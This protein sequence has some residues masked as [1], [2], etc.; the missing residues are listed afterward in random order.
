ML[1]P[2]QP[3]TSAATSSIIN[4]HRHR[5]PP[6]LPD[7]VYTPRPAD[8]RLKQASLPRPFNPERPLSEL[9]RIRVQN[10]IA[11]S[12]VNNARTMQRFARAPANDHESEGVFLFGDAPPYNALFGTQTAYEAQ[13][14]PVPF[15]AGASG[16]EQIF[17]P[18][19]HP[20]WGSCLEN[21]SFYISTASGETA[22]FT[23]FNFCES[24][25]SFVFDAIID[26][27]F[28]KDYVRIDEQGLP[29][30]VS[31]IFTPD[32]QPS[33]TST[34]YSLLY[35]FRHRRYDIVVSAPSN[36][37]FQADAFGWSI[38]EPYAAEG[39]CPRIAPAL[40]TNLSTYNTGTGEWD[41]VSD[42][43]AGGAYSFIGLQ[44]GSPNS[45]F[46]GD[47]GGAAS[48]DFTLLVPNSD[49]EV[50]SPRNPNVL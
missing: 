35:N 24:P 41:A 22:H 1:P 20:A 31:E 44:A 34:W 15:P 16:D 27:E 36:G 23:V 42:N 13:Q 25:A 32:I 48:L 3:G 10:Q 37:L 17:V 18:T 26:R 5:K 2:R 11:G 4:L 39:T 9:G 19:M 33:A 6:P 21:S 50:T 8:V 28:L 7:T 47:S 45:C 46:V 40:V 38:A 14:Q 43:M 49:W 29:S 12:P 30:Y